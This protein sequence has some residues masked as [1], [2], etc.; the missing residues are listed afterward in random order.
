MEKIIARDFDDTLINTAQGYID[1]LKTH[2]KTLNFEEITDHLIPVKTMW[3]PEDD[4]LKFFNQLASSQ[5]HPTIQPNL[6]ALETMRNLS[7]KWYKHYVVT[8]RSQD[9]M[10]SYTIQLS[11]KIFDKYIE[12]IIHVNKNDQDFNEKWPFVKKLWAL[13]FIDDSY[14]QCVSVQ[15]SWIQSYVI[16]KPWNKN[17][18]NEKDKV[19]RL[20][21]IS[22]IEK[23]LK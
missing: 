10:E 12:G 5:I 15:N 2:W 14:W 19:I 9:Y 13:A 18:D 16:N 11:E 7:K 21:E 23:Y 8:S 20:Y 1:Y 6:W 3:L 17:E 4:Y 22:E